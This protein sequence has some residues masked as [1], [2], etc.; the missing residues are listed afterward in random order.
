ML[1]TGKEV[2]QIVALNVVLQITFVRDVLSLG[3]QGGKIMV[4]RRPMTRSQRVLSKG[5]R[6]RRLSIRLLI[7]STLRLSH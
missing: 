5:G 4:M 7:K 3:E 6:S 2:D 1:G